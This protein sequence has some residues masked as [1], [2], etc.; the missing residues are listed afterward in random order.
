MLILVEDLDDTDRTVTYPDNVTLSNIIYFW[1]CPSLTYQIAFPKSR[2]IRPWVV[3][4]ILMKMII[5]ISLF[6][7]VAMQIVAP[8]L[9]SLVN[10]LIESNG[11]YTNHLLM[12]YWLRLSIANTYLW[13]IFFYLYFHLF[14]NLLSEVLRFGGKL[15]KQKHMYTFLQSFIN[16]LTIKCKI[17]F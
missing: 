15:V 9:N 1:C 4:D 13:L 5:T 7:F 2:R 6:M 16:Q 17:S 14:L 11:V 3:L 12:E 10:D 8:A